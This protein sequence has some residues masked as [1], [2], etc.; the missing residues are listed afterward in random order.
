MADDRDVVQPRNT[1]DVAETDDVPID[2]LAY[3]QV[4]GALK[5]QADVLNELRQ[6]TSTL[7][8][9][10]TLVATF[11][12]GQALRAAPADQGPRAVLVV[13]LGALCAGIG[14]CLWVLVV[15]RMRK[16]E[17]ES[18]HNAEQLPSAGAAAPHQ[19]QRWLPR[20]RFRHRPAPRRRPR[21]DDVVALMF[22]LNVEVLLD[23]AED[24]GV[25]MP[26][27]TRMHAART[28]QLHWNENASI[29]ARKQLAFNVACLA[30]A[31]QT[32]SWITFIALG[33]EVI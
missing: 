24:R 2:Q 13:G 20:V 4:T 25:A 6:R 31:M 27:T 21:P 15:T 14:A 30:L 8:A 29:I 7:V 23:H 33:R 5:Q 17:R 32:L 10:T 26:N 1:T 3:E 19:Q 28:L 22:S 11:L 18:T 12:G 9:V 16:R